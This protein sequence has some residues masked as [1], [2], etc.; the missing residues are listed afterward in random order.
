VKKVRKLSG[1][2]LFI[3]CSY[4]HSDIPNGCPS[5]WQEP[6]ALTGY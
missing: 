6:I 5:T 1:L 4:S 2:L 3:V